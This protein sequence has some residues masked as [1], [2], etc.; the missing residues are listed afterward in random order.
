MPSPCSILTGARAP[1][2]NTSVTWPWK[3]AEPGLDTLVEAVTR[4]CQKCF[5]LPPSRMSPA[6]S[7]STEQVQSWGLEQTEE[8]P[9]A[10]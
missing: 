4:L 10:S 6:R 2:G 8:L 9:P 1:A 3:S 7:R 5:Q